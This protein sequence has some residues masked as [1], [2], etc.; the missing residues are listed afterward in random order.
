MHFALRSSA[1][2]VETVKTMAFEEGV[3]SFFQGL[4]PAVIRQALYGSMRFGLYPVFKML[5]CKGECDIAGRLLSG[6]S[7]GGLSSAI[8]NPTDL[9]KIR[10]QA[11]HKVR[12]SR[13]SIKVPTADAN[14]ADRFFSSGGRSPQEK[15][16]KKH[17]TRNLFQY[18][19]FFSAL[20]HIVKT[21][22][23]LALYTGVE[24]TG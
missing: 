7:A 15:S 18:S 9:I 3:R 24:P 4:Q 5:I 20:Q 17:V 8:C 6:M 21:E 1:N 2:L 16:G 10:M 23:F 14:N 11:T 22:G 12:N 13:T 19:G